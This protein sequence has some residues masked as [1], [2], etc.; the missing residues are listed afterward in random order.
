MIISRLVP[1]VLGVLCV[2]QSMSLC[3]APTRASSVQAFHESYFSGRTVEQSLITQLRA[4]YEDAQFILASAIA[5][6]PGSVRRI[7]EI[8]IDEG[9]LPIDIAA[10]CEDA[11][12]PEQL[13]TLIETAL[14]E[15]IDPIPIIEQCLILVKES[16]MAG[17]LAIAINNSTPGQI[18]F[19]IQAAYETLM[20]VSSDPFTLVK[21]GILQSTAFTVLGLDTTEGIEDLLT[22]IRLQDNL[23]NL[24]I[25]EAVAPD[26]NQDDFDNSGSVGGIVVE[27]ENPIEPE[28]PISS[29]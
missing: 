27:P 25:D 5:S 15:R 28:P 19:V 26:D 16:R 3:A 11:L 17:L 20:S 4:N 13:E 29:S 24:V 9:V 14:N 2:M 8:A 10:Q 22:E 1:V 6:S 21:T 7:V 18:E 12:T 23:E